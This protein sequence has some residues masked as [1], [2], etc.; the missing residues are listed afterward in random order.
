M[1][2][3]DRCESVTLISVENCRRMPP[4]F[5]PVEP[6]PSRSRSRTRMSRTPFFVRWYAMEA[7]MIPP[8][9]MTTS[10]VR[11]IV[12]MVGRSSSGRLRAGDGPIIWSRA[13]VSELVQ[14]HAS[15]ACVVRHEGST[16]S[17]GTD[18]TSHVVIPDLPLPHQPGSGCVRIER[19]QKRSRRGFAVLEFEKV[20]S[21]LPL[22]RFDIATGSSDRTKSRAQQVDVE[23][24]GRVKTD[25]NAFI[26][27][28]WICLHG[29]P[30]HKV[31]NG[32]VS[33]H[34]PASQRHE[35]RIRDIDSS[36]GQALT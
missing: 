30:M 23:P 22:G 20:V 26:P 31:Q 29:R 2:G 34:E 25:R 12:A 7:P 10:A 15:G 8:P 6:E 32:P 36:Q 35:V 28:V 5:F 19:G 11:R 18:T 27:V 1:C 17:V 21:T 14:E 16:P 3:S 33:V 24:A 4:A 9:T 13:D